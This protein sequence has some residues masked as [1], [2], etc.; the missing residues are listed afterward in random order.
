MAHL[1]KYLLII[2]I[3]LI[4]GITAG[5]GSGNE[6]TLKDDPDQPVELTWYMIGP[7]PEDLPQVLAAM[8][9]YTKEKINATIKI[10]MFDYGD[11]LNKMNVVASS[12]EHFDICFLASWTFDMRTNATRGTIIPLDDLL[13]KYGKD[14]LKAVDQL[15]WD[16]SKINGKHY[17]IPANKEVA[18][19]DVYVFNEKYVV[20]YNIDVNSIKKLSDLEPYFAKIHK[21]D[22]GVYATGALDDYQPGTLDYLIDPRIPGAI[23]MDDSSCKIINQYQDKDYLELVN[24]FRDFYVKGYLRPDIHTAKQ[25]KDFKNG[26][27]V[28]SILQTQ[29]YADL[30]W[31][32]QYGWPVIVKPFFEPP[33]IVTSGAIGAMMAISAA[34]EHPARAMK[35]L[36]LLNTDPYLRNLVSYG[37]EGVHYKKIGP[38]QINFDAPRTKNYGIPAWSPGNNFILYTVD[39]DPVD[40]WQAF[41][42]FNASGRKS[43]AY[44][45]VFDP[46]P[47]KNEVAALKN[48][49]EEFGPSIERGAVDPKIAIPEFLARAQNAGMEKVFT[50]MQ[51]QVDAWKKSR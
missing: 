28:V 44:G 8:N 37:I 34:S 29:P 42:A 22:P 3:L 51:Q 50:E 48:L 39:K 25:I 6:L 16:G 33:I 21:D 5:C 18:T 31:T 9:K 40:K 19:Q 41:Q 2:C 47:V 20:K 49:A 24:T 7:T 45:F 46:N 23:R 26:N 12:G 17:A 43:P 14:T 30:I 35:F 27:Q 1:K 10:V 11:Y 13:A 15:F 4:I 36:N 38:T 32:R